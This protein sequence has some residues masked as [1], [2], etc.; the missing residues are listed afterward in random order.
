MNKVRKQ[1][2]LLIDTYSELIKGSCADGVLIEDVI[3]DMEDLLR[4]VD[5]AILEELS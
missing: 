2:K 4:L 1:I 5:E 3:V